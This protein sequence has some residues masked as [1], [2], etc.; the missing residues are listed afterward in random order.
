MG[1]EEWNIQGRNT[2]QTTNV[3]NVL[4]PTGTCWGAVQTCF[5]MVSKNRREK[6]LATP[7]TSGHVMGICMCDWISHGLRTP[8]AY[9]IW[10]REALQVILT[11]DWLPTLW[12]VYMLF[13][14][15]RHGRWCPTSL[16]IKF[17]TGQELRIPTPLPTA[18]NLDKFLYFSELTFS[19]NK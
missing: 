4:D 9:A 19:Q 18:L 11:Q 6:H 2:E 5:R 14:G 17:N 10:L 13:S 16:N 7:D 3:V 1:F 12:L 8:R 15:W